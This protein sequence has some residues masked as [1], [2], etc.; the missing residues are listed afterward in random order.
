M[1]S[2]KA[3]LFLSL[4]ARIAGL[5]DNSSIKYFPYVDR[6]LGQMEIRNAAGRYPVSWPCVLI[7]IDRVIFSDN[8]QNTQ[9]GVATVVFRMGFT[10]ISASSNITPQDYREKAIYFYDL[11]QVLHLA[12]QGWCPGSQDGY[13]ALNDVFSSFDRKS[14]STEQRPEDLICV[15]VL[16]YTIGFTDYSAKP[17][18]QTFAPVALDLTTQFI[19][20]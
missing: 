14:S 8:S 20:E 2:H 13:D 10:P 18:T 3:N 4:Q 15:Q 7:N 16:E 9:E 12:L 11:E 1:N 6:D 17:A 19:S 5:Q